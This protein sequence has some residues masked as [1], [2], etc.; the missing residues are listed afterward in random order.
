M[1]SPERCAA[2]LDAV[3]PVVS[4]RVA[5]VDD[6]LP[7]P[8]VPLADDGARLWSAVVAQYD[9]APHELELLGQA[10]VLLDYVQF[11]D[12]KLAAGGWTMPGR[13]TGMQVPS[14]WVRMQVEWRRQ[15][16]QLL[17]ELALPDPADEDIPLPDD[18]PS[19][20]PGREPPQR[21][22]GRPGGG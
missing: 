18:V 9:L 3:S 11:A 10:A 12:E 7:Q 21:K 4:P 1:C 19:L 16:A 17:A 22:T 20:V 6:G 14:P 2:A 8:P 15:F 5:A 13:Y